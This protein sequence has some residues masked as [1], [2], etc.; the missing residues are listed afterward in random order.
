MESCKGVRDTDAHQLLDAVALRE[1]FTDLTEEIQHDPRFFDK[2]APILREGHALAA[3]FHNL[4][5]PFLFDR[6][7]A[8]RQGGLRH[9]QILR[10]LADAAFFI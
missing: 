5:A 8:L 10:R 9:V 6:L 1:M 4:H 7:D 2:V 3:P